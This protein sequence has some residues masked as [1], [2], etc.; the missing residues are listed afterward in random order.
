MIAALGLGLVI[1][2]LLGLLGGGGS[3]L[4]VPALVYGVGVPVA[5]AIPT[6]LVV[7][8]ISS[9]AALL[10]RLAGGQIRW[11][12]AGI[13]GVTGAGAAFA[14]AVVN[15]LL[16]PRLVLAGFALLMIAAGFRMLAGATGPAGTAPCPGAG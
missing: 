11:G 16:D 6:S 8:G 1:G 9:A 3:I 14:G 4:A 2:I 15:R 13:F 12:I 10:P 7:V 5:A